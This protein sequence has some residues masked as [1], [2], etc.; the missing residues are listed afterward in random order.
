MDVS[1]NCTVKGAWPLVGLAVKL[2]ANGGGGA[3]QFV[4]VMV[5]LLLL[6]APPLPVAVKVTV[7]VPAL[8]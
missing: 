5:P 8:V 4:T 1:V 7:K 3:V 6:V 2:A